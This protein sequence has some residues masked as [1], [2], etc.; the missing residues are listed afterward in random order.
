MSWRGDSSCPMGAGG[1]GYGG[2]L[3]GSLSPMRVIRIDRIELG[4]AEARSLNGCVVD[5]DAIQQAGVDAR[6]LLGLNFLKAYRLTLDFPRG[7]LQLQPP[8]E[9]PAQ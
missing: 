1:I 6:G 5:L 8:D 3:R 4:D 2:G 9:R 7:V